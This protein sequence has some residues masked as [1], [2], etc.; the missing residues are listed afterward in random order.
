MCARMLSNMFSTSHSL[1]TDYRRSLLTVD[2]GYAH[3]RCT[4]Y[5]SVNYMHCVADRY[6]HVQECAKGEG[7]R[8]G[9]CV[10]C[11]NDVYHVLPRARVC[12]C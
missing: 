9:V 11:Q 2:L 5:Y 8:E 6:L 1:R 12:I 4:T 7:R 10:L 3:F